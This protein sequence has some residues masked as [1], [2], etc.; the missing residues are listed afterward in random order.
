MKKR[1]ESQWRGYLRN[2]YNTELVNFAKNLGMKSLNSQ[3]GV[4]IN[5][6]DKIKLMLIHLDRIGKVKI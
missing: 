4:Y 6:E 3:N 1:T 2:M 5:K